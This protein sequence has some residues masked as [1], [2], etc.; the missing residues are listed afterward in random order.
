MFQKS[1]NL[2]VVSQTPRESGLAGRWL[3]SYLASST[4]ASLVQ[5]ALYTFESLL[6]R[7][8]LVHPHV[9][10]YACVISRG[11]RLRLR[12]LEHEYGTRGVVKSQSGVNTVLLLAVGKCYS[13]MAVFGLVSLL[14]VNSK[15]T[16]RQEICVYLRML[17]I[18][19]A[20]Q[21]K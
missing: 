21:P 18:P 5:R 4:L 6:V 14:M 3:G 20:L 15:C 10:C 1:F 12:R 13:I 9:E 7:P 11:E 2:P 19:S 8:R 16:Y 17:D